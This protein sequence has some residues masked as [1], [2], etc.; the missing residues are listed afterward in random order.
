MFSLAV[1]AGKLAR[2]PHIALLEE[3]NAREGFLEP[4]EFESVRSHL[5]TDLVD[6]ATFAYL[7]GWRAGAIRAL[8]WRDVAFD[9][10]GGVVVGGTVRLRVATSKNRR[11]YE[12]VLLGDLLD[13]MV[14]RH[15]DRRLACPFVFHRGG[16][17]IGDFR[18]AWSRACKAAGHGGRTFHDLRRSAVRN[19][20]RAGVPERVAMTIS[21]HQTRSVFDRYNITSERDLADAAEKTLRYV[22]ERTRHSSVV[23]P[24]G[25]A[26]GE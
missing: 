26:D 6:V 23:V 14:R 21:G 15:E 5:R 3:S 19:M 7:T 17:P 22:D 13:L 1:R 20:I 10:R 8:E 24:I 18:R 2:A 11:P 9:R 16:R 25:S 12:A 4:E